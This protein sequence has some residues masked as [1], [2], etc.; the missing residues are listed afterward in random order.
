MGDR[1]GTIDVGRKLGAVPLLKGEVGSPFN[2]MWPEPRPY[3]P[4]KW[5]LDPS[6]CF[7]TTDMG[8]KLWVGCAPFVG[9]LGPHLT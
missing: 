9:E 8:Q 5:H 2:T 6:S 3:L 7:I 1:L 4:T